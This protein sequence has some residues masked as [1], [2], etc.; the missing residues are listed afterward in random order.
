[1]LS[2][3]AADGHEVHTVIPESGPLVSLLQDHGVIVHIYPPLAI[4]DRFTF[5]SLPNFFGFDWRFL[6]SVY[7]L[8]TMILRLRVDIVYT[9]ASVIPVA[10]LAATL[11][12]RRHFWHI[13]EFF[14]EF[15]SAWI[16]YQWY[17]GLLSSN[18]IANSQATAQQFTHRLR[19]KC[20]V[21]YNG[22]NNDYGSVSADEVKRFRST[23]GDPLFL[24]GVVGRIKW[25]RKG[26]EVLV[27]AAAILADEFPHVRYVIVGSCAPGYEDHLARLIA[28]IQEKGLDDRF[29]LTGDIQETEQVYAA[30]DVTVVPS[31]L[32]E[33]FGSV[34][35]ESMACGTPVIGS[36]TGGISEQIVDG[37]TGFLFSPGDEVD[38]A[39]ALSIIILDDPLRLRMSDAG[40][41]R[42]QD[43][44]ALDGAYQSFV[45]LIGSGSDKYKRPAK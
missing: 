29:I 22:L 10:A 45:A 25:V 17:I 41:R 13:R 12:G 4:I 18:I 2:R 1:M 36:R 3:L 9:N 26:Q 24:V 30:C 28:L 11:T 38:L 27:K 7:W 44:F 32:P 6:R 40:R 37:I 39:R 23:L 19:R 14:S 5:R 8:A 20:L 42:I 34:V 35:M 15:P 33:P 16:L 43:A 21:I 31:V